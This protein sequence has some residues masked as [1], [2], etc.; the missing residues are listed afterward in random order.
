MGHQ[1]RKRFYII[2]VV[3]IKKFSTTLYF[4]TKL[5]LWIPVLFKNS[6]LYLVTITSFY[7]QFRPYWHHMNN[8]LSNFTIWKFSSYCQFI[9]FIMWQLRILV[10][11][12]N[13]WHFL[14]LYY[15]ISSTKGQVLCVWLFVMVIKI[16]IYCG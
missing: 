15:Y 10:M 2:F 11:A 8:L 16:I 14:L 7:H 6:S 1:K 9:I 13:L 5:L 4:I 12:P 3:P